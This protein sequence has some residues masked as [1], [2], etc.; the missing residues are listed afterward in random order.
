MIQINKSCDKLRQAGTWDLEPSTCSW[1]DTSLSNWLQRNYKGLKITTCTCS[2]GSYKQKDTE[3]PQIVCHF[4]G[5]ESKSR[6]GARSLHIARPRGW[7]GSKIHPYHDAFQE[8]ASPPLKGEQVHLLLVFAPLCCSTGRTKALSEFLIWPLI[9]SYRL[10]S[11]RIQISIKLF[12][13]F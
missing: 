5:A 4:W 9:H 1:K 3:N 13:I 2:W 6:Y 11:S 10:K 12:W 8:P 7:P